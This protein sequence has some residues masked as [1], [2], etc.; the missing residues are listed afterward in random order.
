MIEDRPFVDYYAILQVGRQCSSKALEAAYRHCAKL[1][2]PDHT[3][4]ADVTKFNEVIEAYRVLRDAEQRARYDIEYAMRFGPEPAAIPSV[5]D[6]ETEETVALDDAEA[7][8]RILLLLYKKRRESAENA[9][10]AG[11]YIQE[12]LHCSD[13]LLE[14]HRW[15]LKAKGFVEIT[16]QGTMAI[17]IAGIDH[18]MSMSRSHKAEKLLIA[19]AEP[20]AR[21]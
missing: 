8:A 20:P 9:G 15:Y 6:G 16:E 11:Y 3:D 2:H 18:V 17:T 12:L 1:Y 19:Q 14:F 13:E 10:V 7:H 21:D 5:G 4:T